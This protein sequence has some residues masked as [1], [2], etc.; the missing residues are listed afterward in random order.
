M[1]RVILWGIVIISFVALMTSG[2][3]C[4][5]SEMTSAKLYIS[6]KDYPD[7][8]KQ[9]MME[10]AK[11][12]KN[13]EAYFVLGQVRYYEENFVGMKEAFD[14]ALAIDTTHLKDIN[15]Y[16]LVVWGKLYNEGVEAI[17]NAID[18]AQYYDE[19]IKDFSIAVKVMPE[20]IYTERNLGL[21]YFRKGNVEDALPHLEIAI[22]KAK[23]LIAC[24]LVGKIYLDSASMMKA[25]FNDVN[26]DQLALRANLQSLREGTM[27]DDAKMILGNPET[28]NKPKKP[29]KGNTKEEWIYPK[30]NLTLAIENGEVK[31][32]T[33]SVPFV[34]TID[35]TLFRSAITLYD[36]AIAV[37]KKGQ[38]WFPEDAEISGNLMN[39]YI[40]A[41]RTMEARALLDDRVKRF[42]NSKYDHYNL[43]VF[44]LKDSNYVDAIGQF[45]ETVRLDSIDFATADS[46]NRAHLDTTFAYNAIYN[47]AAAYVDWGVQEQHRLQ[48]ANKE[49]DFSFKEKFR[50]ALPYLEQTVKRKTS[51][52][53]M[54]ELLGQVYANLNQP[55][56]AQEAFKKADEIRQEFK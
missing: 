44:L 17:N 38:A 28:I 2:F 7:A 45:K 5:S 9:L 54:W 26:H 30:Y 55:D 46:A 39:S 1:N 27:A 16:K 36:K 37:S 12:P 49:D 23:D 25:K 33:F 11:N 13:E 32:V 31:T 48:A 50:Q 53:Q 6:R 47:I 35:S 4:S 22:D 3:Q 18:S 24:K 10:V 15:S 43:G 52:V 51:D 20:S 40:G 21:A 56:K 19:A 8:E 41:E 14:S 29:K 34:P 42:P